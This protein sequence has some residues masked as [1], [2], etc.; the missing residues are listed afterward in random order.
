[1]SSSHPLPLPQPGTILVAPSLLASDFGRLADEVRRVETAG[2]DVLHL[3]VMDGHFV[4]NLTI[5]PALVEAVR[6]NSAMPFD[7]HLMLEHP[8]QFV[9]AFVKAGADHITVHVESRADLPAV[10]RAIRAAGCTT[11]LSLRPRTPAAAILP[12]LPL[13]DLVLV[14][15]VEPGFGGQSFME[16]QIPKIKELHEAIASR[17]TPVHLEVDGGVGSAT[18]PRVVAAGANLLVAGTSVFRAPDAAAAI[19]ALHGLGKPAVG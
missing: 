18:A 15:T 12:Y 19:A 17:G 1:M 8:E 13:L 14:M 9:D 6:K 10:L 11:G 4:P 7:V 3:D 2:A 16:D 5:G